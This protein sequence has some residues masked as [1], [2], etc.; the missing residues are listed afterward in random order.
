M[1]YP[2]PVERICAHQIAAGHFQSCPQYGGVFR[3]NG[4]IEREDSAISVRLACIL[5]TEQERF[6]VVAV[7]VDV[8]KSANDVVAPNASILPGSARDVKSDILL[9][10]KGRFFAGIYG[11]VEV[12][13]EVACLDPIGELGIDFE[14]CILVIGAFLPS[15]VMVGVCHILEIVFRP[16]EIG[17]NHSGHCD[18]VRSRSLGDLCPAHW[19]GVGGGYVCHCPDRDRA[20][21]L[22]FVMPQA[23]IADLYPVGVDGVGI[24]TCVLEDGAVL[25]SAV[26]NGYSFVVEV[27]FYAAVI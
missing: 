16:A 22:C 5:A 14:F 15:A 1:A 17:S 27:V 13:G 2:T 10:G 26:A 19:A 24:E 3:Y 20:G 25:P 21:I 8:A 11:L 12:V 23:L 18:R 7:K 9:V 6:I 4:C